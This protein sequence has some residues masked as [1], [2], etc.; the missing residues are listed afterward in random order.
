MFGKFFDLI[1]LNCQKI[2]KYRWGKYGVWSIDNGVIKKKT[3]TWSSARSSHWKRPGEE[4]L[5]QDT[6]QRETENRSG[7]ITT[8]LDHKNLKFINTKNELFDFRR[9][10]LFFFIMPGHYPWIFLDAKCAGLV[11]VA[12]ICI[13]LSFFFENGGA[14]YRKQCI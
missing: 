2:P 4:W 8:H 10:I 12:Y 6:I 13:C 9:N 3:S 1:F 14:M 7:H 11:I 5:K